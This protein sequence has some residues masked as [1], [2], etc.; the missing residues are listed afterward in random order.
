MS[1]IGPLI[2]GAVRWLKP[3]GLLAVEHD[4]TTSAVTVQMIT[5]TGVFADVTAHPDLT[6]R[7]RFVTARTRR[8][9]RR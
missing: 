1:V 3:G 4:D 2:R 9:D 5:G 7:P 8:G 6:G